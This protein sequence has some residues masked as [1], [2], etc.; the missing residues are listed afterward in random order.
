MDSTSNSNNQ[1]N[2]GEITSLSVLA[3]R[4]MWL[5]VGPI[6]LGL[7]AMI[8]VSRKGGWFTRLDA[9]FGILLCLAVLGRWWEQRSG[10]TTTASGEPSTYADCMRY[11]LLLVSISE[12]ELHG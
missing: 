1:H 12:A 8:I 9:L 11:I 6:G 2:P 10:E 4:M 5:L 7:T 3:A